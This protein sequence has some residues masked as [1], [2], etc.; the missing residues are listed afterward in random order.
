MPCY[1]PR[2]SSPAAIRSEAR[3]E[4]AKEFTHNSPVAE[5]LC[6]V[7]KIIHPQDRPI[8]ASKV[9]G[10]MEWMLEHEAR[11]A[12]KEQSNVRT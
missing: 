11:D 2:D 5:M 6:S 10:L 7:M 12:A 3:G 9:P 4:F 1:D 8:V